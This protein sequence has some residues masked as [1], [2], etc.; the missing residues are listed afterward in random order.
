MLIKYCGNDCGLKEIHRLITDDSYLNS[1]LDKLKKLVIDNINDEKTSYEINNIIMFFY[2]EYFKF[3]NR[4]STIIKSEITRLT[5]P[6]VTEYEI[7]NKYGVNS[8][9]I[10]IKFE[11]NKP[12]IIIFSMNIS[13]KFLL[14]K[15]LATFIKLEFQAEVLQN[16]DNPIETFCICDEY[17]E[18]ANVQDAHFL[19]LS[20]EAKCMNIYSMQSYSSLINSI[21]NEYASKVI[22]QNMVN[23]IWFRNDDNYTI[24]EVVKQIGL[25]KKK[26]KTSSIS[27]G[28]EESKKT[29]LNGFKN[30]KSNI[31]RTISYAENNDYIISTKFLNQELGT[32]E[33][34][35]LFGVGGKFEKVQKIKFKRGKDNEK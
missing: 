34:L 30:K 33:A 28:A 29:I 27:E 15:I 32:L 1:C 10:K 3:D 18:F 35:A 31:S 12:K 17:Q 20:R 9:S 24:E 23:K 6:F 21:K 26:F 7:C 4:I 16:L 11:S 13:K 2:N 19:S 22:I 5:I 14:S 8:N 25:E